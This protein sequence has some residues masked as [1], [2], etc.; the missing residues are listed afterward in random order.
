MHDLADMSYFEIILCSV[1]YQ[2]YLYF[3]IRMAHRGCTVGELGLMCF[4]GVALSME[5][6]NMTKARVGSLFTMA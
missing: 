2:L 1:L 5:L 3:A 4:G 6:M